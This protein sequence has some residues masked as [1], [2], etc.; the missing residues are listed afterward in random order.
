MHYTAVTIASVLSPASQLKWPNDVIEHLLTDSR[1]LVD[2][3]HTLFFA[4]QG[5]GRSGHL[6]VQELY[7]RGVRN[8]VLPKDVHFSEMEA[9]VFVV[10]NTLAAL[11]QLAAFHRNHFSFPVIGITGS[12]GKTVVKEWLYQLLHSRFQLVRSPRSFNSQ[13]GVPLSIWQMSKEHELALF[14]AG[15]STVGEMDKLQAIIR[16]TIGVLTNLGEAH[17]EGFHSREEKLREKFRLFNASNLVVLPHHLAALKTNSSC[18]TWGKEKE[19]NVQL[20][21]VRQ[22]KSGS[23]IELGFKEQTTDLHIPFTD[24]ASI[25]NAV[26]CFCVL[27]ALKLNPSDYLEGFRQLHAVDMRLQLGH[28]FNDCL[29]VNDSYSTDISSLRIAL[30]FMAQQSSGLSR[31][32]VLSDFAQTGKPGQQLY[33]EVLKLLKIYDIKKLI[34]IGAELNEFLQQHHAGDVL[35]QTYPSTEDFI[36]DFKS[37]SFFREIILVK[38]ARRFGFERIAA[39]FEERQHQTVLEINL[40]ALVHNVKQYRSVL[41]PQVK[42]MA[43]VKAFAYGSGAAEIAGILQSQSVHY[44]AVAYADEG[45]ELVK[46]GIRLPIMVMNTEPNAFQAIATHNLQPVLFSPGLLTKWEAYL[47]EQGLQN[48]PVHIE[49]ETGMNRLGFLPEQIQALATQLSTTKLLQVQSVFTHLAASEDP[50]QD[51]FT[52]H[53]AQ[54]FEQGVATLKESLGYSFLQHIANSAAI[55]RHPQLQMDM[56]RLGI[57]LYGVEVA[58]GDQLDLHP[59]ATLR[60]TIAQIRKVA[61]GESVSYNRKGVVQ[62]DSLIATVRIGY[63]DGYSRRFGHGVGKMLVRGQLAPVTGTVCMD[64]TMIDVT[65]IAGVQEGDEVILFGKGLSIEAVAASIGTIPYEIMTGVSQRVKRVYYN[66]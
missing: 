33:G 42:L 62:R 26:T 5:A 16:P 4:L 34:A 50:E 7:D 6:F 58:G 2:P 3:A 61:K 32:V 12:N 52:L 11:Q 40:N 54:L 66:E 27:L 49:L 22:E 47:Q 31:T 55:V 44:L 23:V 8:F 57:G 64:M 53:Q 38:G 43:M 39:L 13:I 45:V 1:Q 48:Y 10:E 21:A 56:V 37:S 28:G 36:L 15:I 20:K 24:E 41:Q 30:Q 35:V 18:I 63:A 17:D 29:I 9:N 59:V 25:Q 46:A 51:A 19:A 65:D 60:S 14:E